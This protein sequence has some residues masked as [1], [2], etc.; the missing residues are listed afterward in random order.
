MESGNIFFPGNSYLLFYWVSKSTWL[1]GVEYMKI[2]NLVGYSHFAYDRIGY[3]KSA[4]KRKEN[5]KLRCIEKS[6]K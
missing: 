3:T 4:W 1:S 5:N 6:R 2:I